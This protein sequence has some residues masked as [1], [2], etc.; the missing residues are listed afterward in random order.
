MISLERFTEM[1]QDR[2][3]V[4]PALVV[5]RRNDLS[6]RLAHIADE[7]YGTPEPERWR[8]P[9]PAGTVKRLRQSL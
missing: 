2:L 8:H 1:I 4:P 9:S 6:L 7:S 3:H 5:V